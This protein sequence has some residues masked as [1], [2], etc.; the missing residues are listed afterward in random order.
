MDMDAASLRSEIEGHLKHVPD[1]HAPHGFCDRFDQVV[2]SLEAA[3][4]D[5]E[6]A[7]LEAQ[8]HQIRDEAEAAGKCADCGPEAEAA[9][10]SAEQS[11]AP[12]EPAPGG[13]AAESVDDTDGG[14]AET[15]GLQRILV[16]VAIVVVI[17]FAAYYLLWR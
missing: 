7:A 14:P 12:G 15:G 1:E 8:L 2:A 13:A 16:P 5:E 3:G 4:D 10:P 6:R 17:L 9:A 11:I